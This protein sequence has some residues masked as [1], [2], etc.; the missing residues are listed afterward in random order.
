MD[1]FV[2]LYR[3]SNTIEAHAIK[4]LLEQD[5]ILVRVLGEAL[6]GAVGELPV[7]AQEVRVLVEKCHQA[8]ALDRLKRYQQSLVPWQCPGCGE[9]NDGHFD[10]CWSCGAEPE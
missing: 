8:K 7:D 9:Q 6:G 2:E 4:G 5:G 3:A 10:V 1:S